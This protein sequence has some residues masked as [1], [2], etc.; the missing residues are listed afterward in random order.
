[1]D[2]RYESPIYFLLVVGFYQRN[3]SFFLYGLESDRYFKDL[4]IWNMVSWY[5]RMVGGCYVDYAH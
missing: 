5:S 1:M 2:I 3:V 4:P